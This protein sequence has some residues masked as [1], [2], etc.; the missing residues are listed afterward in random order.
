MSP[1]MLVYAGTHPPHPRHPIMKAEF[2]ELSVHKVLNMVFSIFLNLLQFNF[3]VL[4]RN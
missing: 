4:T 3:L 2:F 1:N